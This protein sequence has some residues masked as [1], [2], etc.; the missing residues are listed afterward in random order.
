MRVW[1]AFLPHFGKDHQFI[2]VGEKWVNFMNREKNDNNFHCYWAVQDF[3][4]SSLNV[5]QHNEQ[6]VFK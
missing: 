3:T 6:L 1:R 5:I 2:C 4:A